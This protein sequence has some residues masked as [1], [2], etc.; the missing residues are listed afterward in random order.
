MST[1]AKRLLAA[2]DALPDDDREA[3]V[4]ELLSRQPAGAGELP[5]TALVEMADEL[6]RS[7]DAKEAGNA[8]PPR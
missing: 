5:D 6:F 4:A 8:T 7:Y 3:V 1:A 2:F